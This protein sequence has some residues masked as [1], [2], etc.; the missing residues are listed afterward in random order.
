M[1]AVRQSEAR[2]SGIISSVSEIPPTVD[3]ASQVPQAKAVRNPW[4]IAGAWLAVAFLVPPLALTAAVL[5][6]I[7]IRRADTYHGTGLRL[8]RF[9]LSLGLIGVALIPIEYLA[10]RWAQEKSEQVRCRSQLSAL[11]WTVQAYAN[12][13]R[14]QLPPDLATDAKEEDLTPRIFVCECSTDAVASSIAQLA[15]PGHISY[16]YLGAGKRFVDVKNPAKQVLM[17]EQPHHFGGMNVA[18]FD[19]HVEFIPRA[20]AAKVIAELR[21]GQNPPPSLNSP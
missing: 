4:A 11:A 21:S 9:A 13:N 3:Y 5:G 6:Y 20:K 12:A 16:V 8:A 1:C 10:L 15:T 17:Y 7:G 19:G 2:H 14:D 18:F